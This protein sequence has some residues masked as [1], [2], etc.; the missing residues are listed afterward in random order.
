MIFPR[1]ASEAKSLIFRW[2]ACGFEHGMLTAGRRVPNKRGFAAGAFY[3]RK[4]W[5]LR[6][7]QPPQSFLK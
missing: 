1:P 6:E 7:I 2:L 5:L 3:S 4:F